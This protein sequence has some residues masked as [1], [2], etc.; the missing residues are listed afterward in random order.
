MEKK[1][2]VVIKKGEDLSLLDKELAD[3]TGNGVIPNRAVRLGN[4]LPASNRVTEWLLTDEEAEELKKDPRVLDV[5]DLSNFKYIKSGSGSIPCKMNRAVDAN[6]LQH[7]EIEILTNDD[8]VPQV[9]WALG[10]HQQFTDDH[11]EVVQAS[12]YESFG[13]GSLK[14]L[15][16]YGDTYD[17]DYDGEGVDIVILDSGTEE[18][19]P[20]WR[21]ADG[22]SRF[23]PINWQ[24]ETGFKIMLDDGTGELE[25]YQQPA[26]FYRDY[27]GHGTAVASLAAGYY[28]GFAKGAHIYAIKML[29]LSQPSPFP[30]GTD[31][32]DYYHGYTFS[33]SVQLIKLW[34]EQKTN[35]RPT[36]VN[37]SFGSSARVVPPN[38]ISRRGQPYFRLMEDGNTVRRTSRELAELTGVKGKKSYNGT[39]YPP[40]NAAGTVALDD[41]TWED[42]HLYVGVQSASQT[43][44]VDE[45]IEAGIHVCIAAGNDNL[46]LDVD[47]NEYTHRSNYLKEDSVGADYDNF[48]NTKAVG[49]NNSY[50][51][52][53][54]RPPA[55]YHPD[56]FFVGALDSGKVCDVTSNGVY[57]SV[58]QTSEY[59][60]GRYVAPLGGNAARNMNHINEIK[61]EFSNHGAAVNMYAAGVDTKAAKPMHYYWNRHDLTTEDDWVGY[62]YMYDKTTNENKGLIIN[63]STLGDAVRFYV[64]LTQDV[65]DELQYGSSGV[66]HTLRTTLHHDFGET[67]FAEL[68]QNA[69]INDPLNL[70]LT[71]DEWVVCFDTSPAY[72][73]HQT[74]PQQLVQ[75]YGT[76]LKDYPAIASST[77]RRYSNSALYL[78]VDYNQLDNFHNSSGTWI[79]PRDTTSL[80]FTPESG[81]QHNHT[82]AVN[83]VIFEIGFKKS[84]YSEYDDVAKTWNGKPIQEMFKIGSAAFNHLVTEEVA[85]YDPDVVNYNGK[86][87]YKGTAYNFDSGTSMASPVVAGLL[88]VNIEKEGNKTPK[89]YVDFMS[90]PYSSYSDKNTHFLD[91]KK[92][93]RTSV[94]EKAE[95]GLDRENLERIIDPEQGQGAFYFVDDWHSFYTA[96]DLENKTVDYTGEVPHNNM[97]IGSK[98]VAA[99][100]GLNRDFGFN[101]TG[102]VTFY[103]GAYSRRADI[104]LFPPENNTLT[105]PNAI[106]VTQDPWTSKMTIDG[107]YYA[108]QTITRQ[109]AEWIPKEFESDSDSITFA[110]VVSEG[111]A[112]FT[113]SFE[114]NGSVSYNVATA[115]NVGASLLGQSSHTQAVIN[116]L[117]L[118]PQ[119][120]G[121]YSNVTILENNP[122]WDNMHVVTPTVAAVGNYTLGIRAEL[123]F[124]Y[125]KIVHN[126]KLWTKG[127]S[128]AGSTLNPIVDFDNPDMPNPL[129]VKLFLTDEYGQQSEDVL[130]TV[131]V[132]DAPDEEPK[133]TY[134]SLGTYELSNFASGGL[135]Y[136]RVG[137]ARGFQDLISY[138][139]T[140]ED[141]DEADITYKVQLKVNGDWWTED[142][143]LYG[144]HHDADAKTISADNLDFENLPS[145][146]DW[147]QDEHFWEYT[148]RA[149]TLRF[150]AEDSDGNITE[151]EFLIR[152]MDRTEQYPTFSESDEAIESISNL[153]PNIQY[154]ATIPENTPEGTVIFTIPHIDKG[155]YPYSYMDDSANYTWTA[156]KDSSSLSV[157][158][159]GEVYISSELDFEAGETYHMWIKVTNT[160]MR[161]THVL[162]NLTV[163]DVF[164]EPVTFL[165]AGG[166]EVT[167]VAADIV[168]H[169]EGGTLIYE[170][171]TNAPA[172]VS[173]D[174]VMESGSLSNLAVPSGGTHFR[175][176]DLNGNL[177][178]EPLSHGF[179]TT[180]NEW[181]PDFEED[182]EFYVRLK[183]ENDFGVTYLEVYP[184]IIDDPIKDDFKVVD[185]SNSGEE[186]VFEVNDGTVSGTELFTI[187]FNK[188]VNTIGSY[189]FL[190]SRA[191]DVEGSL[192]ADTNNNI[193]GIDIDKTTGVIT[194]NQDVD[195]YGL[196]EI[197]PFYIIARD[198]ETN[199]TITTLITIR[200]VNPIEAFEPRYLIESDVFAYNAMVNHWMG[201]ITED[202]PAGTTLLTVKF[203]DTV[204][205]DNLVPIN[206]EA[207]TVTENADPTSAYTIVDNGDNTFDIQT[208]IALDYETVTSHYLGLSF[209]R[210]DGTGAQVHSSISGTKDFQ[211][212]VNNVDEAA[213]VWL[214]AQDTFEISTDTAVGTTIFTFD[215]SDEL[216]DTGD[217]ASNPI[218]YAHVHAAGF[219]NQYFA[220]DVN[221]GEVTVTAS[222]IANLN[223]H[224]VV[225]AVDAA[226]NEAYKTFI[227]NTP[228]PTPRVNIFNEFQNFS[229]V[230]TTG[231]GTGH[232]DMPASWRVAELHYENPS[233]MYG[234]VVI[235]SHN[236]AN[237]QW[238]N[239]I[240][241]AGWQV[242]DEGGAVVANY[243]NLTGYTAA[244]PYN[245]NYTKSTNP[246][247][248][249]QI[250]SGYQG[251]TMSA[252]AQGANVGNDG[253]YLGRSTASHNTGAEHGYKIESDEVLDPDT[254]YTQE[255]D[256]PYF[257]TEMSGAAAGQCYFM[258]QGYWGTTN[259]PKRGSI[260]IMYFNSGAS[261]IDGDDTL[262]VGIGY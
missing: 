219:F 214:N 125:F 155:D 11:A 122:D 227:I 255:T 86:P 173:Y 246:I 187:D 176:T 164:D 34:H 61:P 135:W 14:F 91:N 262:A 62:T 234:R 229:T 59:R 161:S 9:N 142:L 186:Y 106:S 239:D 41:D 162:I 158:S 197:Y 233:Q 257:F 254:V 93:H 183:A 242:L 240:A 27:D 31:L 189:L 147:F 100:A 153:P 18:H 121:D 129:Q 144:L 74:N 209:N 231:T 112:V 115:A 101:I 105:V 45:L 111:N 145:G 237:P 248:A 190:T 134:S 83:R 69:L 29:D 39:G 201:T 181:F 149:M 250:F 107:N 185:F 17:Y 256:E 156:G 140:D 118:P 68:M 70:S 110:D 166:T 192:S 6:T 205:N 40:V 221:T 141:S 215:T 203:V 222:L 159:N 169:S 179:L 225:K 47:L 2:S 204:D 146:V 207:F 261:T 202:T 236:T 208:A 71:K 167:M 165:N 150:T 8:P 133:F 170:F 213:P 123:D 226:G 120:I 26:D 130:V 184:D 77:V 16:T 73:E 98:V 15:G 90:S 1:Y 67:A 104:E 49:S 124:Q 12:S 131:T 116:V 4:A 63:V 24:D 108:N 88:A 84:K 33:E 198:A 148:Y 57:T 180:D 199:T 139:I 253:W 43:A 13:E 247:A 223:S 58:D 210:A 251:Y 137:E 36:I 174:I 196:R 117:P 163:T 76:S 157:N 232:T 154:S 260:R 20:E 103:S 66:L 56:A 38:E 54:N 50:T 37:M 175:V 97:I 75:P 126:S 80:S 85:A 114:N 64:S 151:E 200:V 178:T 128:S 53:Y 191:G 96:R 42:S 241:V 19:H 48:Y 89:E 25:Q 52:Y 51:W 171:R 65:I 258:C 212:S 99:T 230:V 78:G 182:A 238:Q 81:G 224:I 28:N 94:N 188:T 32:N 55:P 22:N 172:L 95:I 82:S 109:D 206:K 92:T 23:K 35:G 7:E 113:S 228:P 72:S 194:L 21:D 249:A 211:L 245:V 143:N 30:E 259:I 252:Q 168:E 177:A 127:N 132:T 79:T 102:D 3:S 10:R 216:A 218:T 60:G 152:V 5:E 195:Y 244:S 193:Q 138:A 235:R 220:F 46:K 136:V 119:I 160:F 87:I 243:T 44:L 217:V